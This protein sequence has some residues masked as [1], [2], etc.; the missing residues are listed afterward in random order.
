MRAFR[1]RALVSLGHP[2]AQDGLRRMLAMSPSRAASEVAAGLLCTRGR[3]GQTLFYH[4]DLGPNPRR[5]V[6]T[7]WQNPAPEAGR[8]LFRRVPIGLWRW[9]T[10]DSVVSPRAPWVAERELRPHERAVARS[11][12]YR[13]GS[14]ISLGV[15]S[16]GSFDPCLITDAAEWVDRRP[17]RSLSQR[18]IGRWSETVVGPGDSTPAHVIIARM[19]RGIDDHQVIVDLAESMKLSPLT[20]GNRMRVERAWLETMDRCVTRDGATHRVI[21]PRRAVKRFV[22]ASATFPQE[23]WIVRWNPG[24]YCKYD[25]LFSDFVDRGLRMKRARRSWDVIDSLDLPDDPL[26]GTLARLS[27]VDDDGQ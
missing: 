15:V 4:R 27:E 17:R 9:L 18:I 3:L 23:I 22:M 13:H 16:T 24:T 11:L 12:W 20:L 10:L 1:G 14:C 26:C 8:Y 7:L 6:D 25:V 2:R 19:L 5:G 21:V